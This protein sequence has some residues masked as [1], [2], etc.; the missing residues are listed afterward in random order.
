MDDL[1]LW[2]SRWE[3]IDFFRDCRKRW[4]PSNFRELS[5]TL[6]I[7]ASCDSHFCRQ[8]RHFYKVDLHR[9]LLLFTHG[10]LCVCLVSLQFNF[11]VEDGFPQG[12]HEDSILLLIPE[13]LQISSK[14]FY[15]HRLIFLTSHSEWMPPHYAPVP[16]KLSHRLRVPHTR[17]SNSMIV[18][19]SGKFCVDTIRENTD[20]SSKSGPIF[21]ISGDLCHRLYKQL[22]ADFPQKHRSCDIPLPLR[23]RFIDDLRILRYDR[24][25]GLSLRS[26]PPYPHGPSSLSVFHLQFHVF[27]AALLSQC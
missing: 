26:V 19:H 25:Q 24:D 27:D 10:S 14:Q 22:H 8:F 15:G 13:N 23:D 20:A 1:C 5:F 16:G 7:C 6:N 2:I 9:P 3:C 4:L 12:R 11:A 21:S 17:I 18:Q